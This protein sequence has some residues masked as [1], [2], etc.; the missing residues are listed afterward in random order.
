MDAAQVPQSVMSKHI[1]APEVA[2]DDATHDHM[3]RQSAK[4]GDLL[5]GYGSCISQLGLCD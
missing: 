4:P 2:H 3:R 5:R 1:G